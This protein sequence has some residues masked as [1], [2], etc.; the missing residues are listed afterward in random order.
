MRYINQQ[1]PNSNS[2]KFEDL[3]EVIMPLT[4]GGETPIGTN[5]KTKV[6]KPLVYNKLPNNLKRPV[7]V[8]IITDGMPGLEPKSTFV[9]A[10]VECGNRLEEADYPRE[11]EFSHVPIFT[12]CLVCIE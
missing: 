1:I 5:L 7:L 8:S 9:D 11:S 6:L 3:A 4:W 10:I 2:L 12:A